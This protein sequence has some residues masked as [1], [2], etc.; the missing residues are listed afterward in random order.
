[1]PYIQSTWYAYQCPSSHHIQ[2]SPIAIHIINTRTWVKWQSKSISCKRKKSVTQQH[3]QLYKNGILLLSN[4]QWPK[5]DSCQTSHS[6][7]IPICKNEWCHQ[8]PH[9]QHKANPTGRDFHPDCC[10]LTLHLTRRLIPVPVGEGHHDVKRSQEE[11]EVKE[12][13]TVSDSVP[14]VVYSSVDT[15]TLI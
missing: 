7:K 2:N 14:F 8:C 4:E 6:V 10:P 15:I 13:V 5:W 1:M 11:H 12:G 9:I 3:I